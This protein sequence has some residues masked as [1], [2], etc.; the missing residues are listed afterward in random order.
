M[1][2]LGRDYVGPR[3]ELLH[4]WQFRFSSDCMIISTAIVQTDGLIFLGEI[5]LI[6]KMLREDFSGE[7]ILSIVT[8]SRRPD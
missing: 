8:R 7:N 4:D 3:S 2:I 1:S 6:S 5:M